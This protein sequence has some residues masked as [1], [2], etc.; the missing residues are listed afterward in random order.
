MTEIRRQNSKD[1]V[2]RTYH[3]PV[4]KNQR[5]P[6]EVALAPIPAALLPVVADSRSELPT[7]EQQPNLKPGRRSSFTEQNF[8]WCVFSN[9]LFQLFAP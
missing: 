9:V 2:Q 4:V 5:V 6:A 1:N 3:N 8:A 7:S